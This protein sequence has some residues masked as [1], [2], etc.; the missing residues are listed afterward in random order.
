[1]LNNDNEYLEDYDKCSNKDKSKYNKMKNC[2]FEETCKLVIGKRYQYFIFRLSD[3]LVNNKLT[4]M[5]LGDNKILN[6][7][8]TEYNYNKQYEVLVEDIIN[9]R[10]TID[11]V[12]KI[13]GINYL[14]NLVYFDKIVVDKSKINP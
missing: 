13:S 10:A 6:T 12:Y 1:M 5:E 3:E 9:L 4:Q 7:S 2:S 8:Q 11:Q 14:S